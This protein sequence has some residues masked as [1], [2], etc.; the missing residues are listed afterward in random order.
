MVLHRSECRSAQRN[1]S[2]A[3]VHDQ[4]LSGH[5]NDHDFMHHS[6]R[7]CMHDALSGIAD[8]C[9]QEVL[10]EESSMQPIDSWVLV[11]SCNQLGSLGLPAVQAESDSVEWTAYDHLATP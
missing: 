9:Q 11:K 2:M 7:W 5:E 1:G 6:L 4:P 8:C 3:Y 10:Q